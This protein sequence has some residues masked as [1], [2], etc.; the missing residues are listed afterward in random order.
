MA[1]ISVIPEA[2]LSDVIEVAYL[3]MDQALLGFLSP[4]NLS[5]G[6][7]VQ[8]SL[9]MV[10]KV[11]RRWLAAKKKKILPPSSLGVRNEDQSHELS[12]TLLWVGFSTISCVFKD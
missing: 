8:I 2:T 7:N 4:N 5:T 9:E 3:N 11:N 6:I 12:G 1:R 10:I